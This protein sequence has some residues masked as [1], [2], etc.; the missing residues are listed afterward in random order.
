METIKERKL[1]ILGQSYGGQIAINLTSKYPDKVAA[2][3]VEGTFTTFNEEA[4]YQVPFIIKPFVK[5][6]SISP[7]KSKHLIKGIKEV[8]ILVIH[9]SED[10]TVP[11][12]MGQKLY[13]YA[14]SPKYFWEIKGKHV[15]GIEN[16]TKEYLEKI[17]MLTENISATK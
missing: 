13:S 10:T 7:Y 4:V 3:V 17:K 9:S 14:N 11:F 16:N 5:L 12:Q 8:P 1:I 2:L 6:F 15:H